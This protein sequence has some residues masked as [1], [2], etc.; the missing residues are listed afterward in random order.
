V[1]YKIFCQINAFK[2]FIVNADVLYARFEDFAEVNM[3]NAVF[4]DVS[5][6]SISKKRHF[7][8]MYLRSVHRLPVTANV[9]PS[10]P[11]SCYPDDGSAT[12]LRNVGS[13][14]NHTP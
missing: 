5:P 14:K 10:S 12:F 4:W 1:I 7:G 8:G 11:D 13:Y 9:V 2:I 6:R 3:K